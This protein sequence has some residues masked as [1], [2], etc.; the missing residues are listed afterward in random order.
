[1]QPKIKTTF[2][3]IVYNLSFYIKSE[4]STVYVKNTAY[5]YGLVF[6]LKH[7]CAQQKNKKIGKLKKKRTKT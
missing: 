4:A 6:T 5:S 1:M 3:I 2:P 7:F